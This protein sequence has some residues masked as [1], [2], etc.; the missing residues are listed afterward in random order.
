VGGVFVTLSAVGAVGKDVDA[1]DGDLSVHIDGTVDAQG[2]LAQADVGPAELDHGGAGEAGTALTV[3]DGSHG[4]VPREPETRR[5]W[6]PVF[7]F[8]FWTYGSAF[9]GLTGSLLSW[10]TATSAPIVLIASAGTG[11]GVGTLSAWMVRW[12]RRPVG[13]SVRLAD[14]IGSVGEL[15]MPLR[16]GGVTRIKLQVRERERTMLAVA[17]EP[18]ALP[19]GTRVLV[20]GIDETG[21]ARIEPEQNVYTTEE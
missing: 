6:L 9:F 7:S 14:Y 15:V 4:L 12:L 2:Q 18:L 1:D 21:R 13:A 17:T 3:A 20:L 16:E 19:A 10:L 8:R 11:V 5:P